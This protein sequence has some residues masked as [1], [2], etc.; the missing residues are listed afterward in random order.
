MTKHTNDKLIKAYITL[1][2]VKFKIKTEIPNNFL[3]TLNNGSKFVQIKKTGRD[4]IV[5]KDKILEINTVSYFRKPNKKK[6]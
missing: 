2:G 4:C 3:T 6:K 5:P 1:Q